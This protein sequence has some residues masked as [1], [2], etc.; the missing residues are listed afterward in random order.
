MRLSIKF[1]RGAFAGNLCVSSR[2]RLPEQSSYSVVDGAYVNP[3]DLTEKRL[4]GSID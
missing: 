2:Q 3:P 4:E 1:E